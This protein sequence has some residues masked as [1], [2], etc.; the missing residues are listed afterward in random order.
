MPTEPTVADEILSLLAGAGRPMSPSEIADSLPDSD[1][2]YIRKELSRLA[3]KGDLVKPR[4]G[5]YESKPATRIADH[6]TTDVRETPR[7][8]DPDATLAVP[9]A[10]RGHSAGAG[11]VDNGEP[12]GVAQLPVAFVRNLTGG[13]VPERMFWTFVVGDSN[14]PYLADGTPILCEARSDV[15]EAGRYVYW[16]DEDDGDHVKRI[17]PLGRGR[18][19]IIPDNKLYQPRLIEAVEGEQDLVRDVELGHTFKL[20]IQGR[21]LFPPDTG[22]AVASQL[23]DFAKQLLK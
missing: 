12:G 19:L 1:D 9:V 21:V 6:K 20:R 16:M 10:P 5:L 13:N 18:Y 2:S 7:G 14:E 8:Y 17:Q 22:A 11:G 15:S 3:G 23:A 4:R